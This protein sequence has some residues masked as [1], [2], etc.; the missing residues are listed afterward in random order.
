MSDQAG[1]FEDVGFSHIESDHDK[2]AKSQK[3]PF[4]RV[5]NNIA[6]DVDEIRK[7]KMLFF[8]CVPGIIFFLCFS[9]IPMFGIIIAFK[10]FRIGH[11]VFDAPWAE[12]IYK[13]FVFFFKSGHALRVTRNTLFLNAIFLTSGTLMQVALALLLNEVRATFYKRFT[14]SLMLLPHFMSWIVVSVIVKG[15]FASDTGTINNALTAV[16]LSPVSW[17]STPNLWPPILVFAR[18]WKGAGWGAIIYL[19]TIASMDAEVYEAATIDGA[20]R[21]QQLFRIT[22]PMLVPTIIML[23]I[24]AVGKIF[25]GDVGMIYGIVGDNALL[26][27]AVDV[28]DTYVLRALRSLGNIG[29]ASAIG[30]WQ[31]V[32]GLIFVIGC[33][34]L[35]RRY[36]RSAALF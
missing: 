20:T 5:V 24:L 30:L 34:A 27:P 21:F 32:M 22:L 31:S 8:L 18:I 11:G 15:F 12:P 1:R 16:G 33:N 9:Y 2:R 36:E 17:Y 26:Q 23:S 35:A 19:A 3:N 6:R 14:Q 4:K 28:I 7:N 25:Y 10:N 29:M 13:N